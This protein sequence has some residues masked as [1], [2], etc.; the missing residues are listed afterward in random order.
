MD[1]II[2]ILLLLVAQIAAYTPTEKYLLQ[3]N[4][5]QIAQ[6]IE[7]DE[8]SAFPFHQ[9]ADFFRAVI[10]QEN[11]NFLGYHATTADHFIF[12]ECV[13]IGLEER[14]GQQIPEDFY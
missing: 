12:Q 14:Y 10:A 1:K 11:E 7:Q 2:P 6:N 8:E 9:Y 3:V 5:E 13:R 4:E